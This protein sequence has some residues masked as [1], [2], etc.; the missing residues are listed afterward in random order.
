MAKRKVIAYYLHEHEL[1]AAQDALEEPKWTES[2]GLGTMDDAAIAE[3]ERRGMIVEVLDQ[4]PPRTRA[5]RRRRGRTEEAGPPGRAA[6]PGR[7]REPEADPGKRNV[8][9]L[10]LEAPILLQEWRDELEA[11]E[12][13]VLD[14]LPSGELTAYVPLDRVDDVEGLACIESLRLFAPADGGSA[15]F[16]EPAPPPRRRRMR[17]R[18]GALPAEAPELGA[19]AA[20][21]LLFDVLLHR[22]EDIDEALAW[23]GRHGVPLVASGRLKIRVALSPEAAELRELEALPE[24]R[25]V[26]EYVKPT[27]ANEI[28]R[29][30]IGL[31]AEGDGSGPTADWPHDGA[32][33]IVAVADS[34]LDQTHPDFAGRIADVVALGRPGDSSDLHGHGTH[35]AATVLGDGAASGGA[36]R[37]AAPGARLFFQSIMDAHDE[38]A[39]LP[40][41]LDELLAEAYA[42]GA[43]VHNNSWSSPLNGFYTAHAREIDRFVHQHPDLTVVIAAGNAARA[44][45]LNPNFPSFPG[46]RGF[47]D[48]QSVGSPATAK[49]AI[50]VGASRS[51]RGEGGKAGQ[52]YRDFDSSRFPDPP[53][54]E[55]TISGDPECLAAFSARGFSDPRRLK[56]DLVAP[57]TDIVSA[58]AS[59]APAGNF[60]GLLPADS[61]YAY[62]G[63]TS[64]AAPLVAGCAALVRQYYR[65]ERDHAASAAL[66]KATLI[67]GTRR[68][69]GEDAL[70]DHPDLPNVHQGFGALYMPHTYPTD[71]VPWMRLEFVDTWPDGEPC[72]R[73]GERRRFEFD[74]A[75]GEFLR[76]CLAWTDPP[77][78]ESMVNKFAFILEHEGLTPPK[79]LGNH[80]RQAPVGPLDRDNN[81]QI[82]RLD[83]PPPGRYMVALSARLTQPPQHWALV[84]TGDLASGLVER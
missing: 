31:D 52:R 29:R 65:E 79:L 1:A 35:V 34:G 74:V 71:R 8:F 5:A 58:R 57:G 33:E 10:E 68:L 14:Q 82:I 25:Q 4:P 19:P 84:V 46:N 51:S 66:V 28:A 32:G 80:R 83:N 55:Q 26:V 56:P 69:S 61:R 50:T 49:N 21:P 45:P 72:R 81:V 60:W 76:L 16:S 73:E 67:N 62:L 24:V 22:T 59:T 54:G 9:V 47:V 44:T 43:R 30:L 40:L 53:I 3:L 36:R 70:A 15:M 78:G 77:T 64:M 7:P 17:T 75:G 12:V 2:Y 27:I 38:L 13:E 20:E 48:W 41:E 42:A 39:G 37:G 6:L 63:G 11:L 18:G 23:I